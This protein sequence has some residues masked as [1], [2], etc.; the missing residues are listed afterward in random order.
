MT[1][2]LND[3]LE[4]ETAETQPT[5]S[6]PVISGV[7]RPG[8]VLAWAP[9]GVSSCE[10]ASLREGML[11]VGRSSSL[12]WSIDERQLSRRHFRLQLREGV[13]IVEDL[14]SRNGTFVNGCVLQGAAPIEPGGVIRAGGCLFVFVEDLEELAGS[15]GAQSYEMAGRFHAGAILQRL[16]IAART[17]Q[18]I[19]LEGESGV[20]KELAAQALHRVFIELGRGERYVAENAALF[21][22]D[23]D[24]VVSLFGADAGVFTGVGVRTGSIERAREGTLFLDEF[25]NLPLRAQRSLLRYVEEGQLRRLGN[26]PARPLDVRLIFGTNLDVDAAIDD[27]VLAHDLVARLHRLSLPPLRERRADVPSIFLAL[28]RQRIGEEQEDMLRDQ[29]D[30]S[31][32]E[33]LCLA[34]LKRGNVRELQQVVTMIGARMAEGQSASEALEKSLDELLPPGQPLEAESSASRYEQHRAEIVETYLELGGNLSKL[35]STLQQRG[36]RVNRRWLAEFLEKWGV[37]Q[38]RRRK[39][40]Q[41]SS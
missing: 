1:A 26:A 34:E 31:V 24:A 5:H 8:L 25:H 41:P 35:E 20:G 40:T 7:K 11:E 19:L 27:G 16:R 23:D 14:E 33:R 21:A 9:E 38:R 10:R 2:A 37:R 22:G 36:I 30:A 6:P 39:T 3:K 32:F 18:H 15:N 28:L 13:W 17:E 29:L 12:S 4:N